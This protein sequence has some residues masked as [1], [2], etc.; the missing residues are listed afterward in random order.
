MGPGCNRS[1]SLTT[2][3]GRGIRR[4]DLLGGRFE[5]NTDQKADALSAAEEAAR[6]RRARIKEGGEVESR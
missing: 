1:R 2:E 6:E 5:G 4:G 3:G